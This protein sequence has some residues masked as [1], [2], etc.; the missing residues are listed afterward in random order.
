MVEKKKIYLFIDSTEYQRFLSPEPDLRRLKVLRNLLKNKRKRGKP[1]IILLTTDQIIDEYYRGEKNRIN[2]SRSQ[3]VDPKLVITVPK[4]GKK[5]TGVEKNIKKKVKSLEDYF[6]TLRKKGLSAFEG[7][8]AEAKSLLSEILSLGEKTDCDKE[9]FQRAN[10]RVI[11]GMHPKKSQNSIGDAINWEILLNYTD[12]ADFVFITKDT[13]F[14]EE[15]DKLHKTLEDEWAKKHKKSI[16]V[17]PYLDKFLETLYPKKVLVKIQPDKPTV[18][19]KSPRTTSHTMPSTIGNNSTTFVSGPI[20]T[21]LFGPVSFVSTSGWTHPIDQHLNQVITNDSNILNNWLVSRPD[22]P[23]LKSCPFC[24]A[25]K[26]S[27]LSVRIGGGLIYSG[28]QEFMC[29]VCHNKFSV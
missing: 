7:N 2:E 22:I 16:S 18:T 21:S 26:E 17:Y 11:R 29:A 1:Q 12:D 24:G 14:V 15:Q 5:E 4:L 13:D 27:L 8:I 20:D 6:E 19:E 28:N 3:F 23:N 9:V 25:D 10:V